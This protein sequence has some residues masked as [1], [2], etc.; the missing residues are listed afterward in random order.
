[1]SK[2]KLIYKATVG[3][4]IFHNNNNERHG[5]TH[6]VDNCYP[7]ELYKHGYIGKSLNNWSLIIDQIDQH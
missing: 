2:P 7:L 4:L 6:S 5:G 3:Y 1:M